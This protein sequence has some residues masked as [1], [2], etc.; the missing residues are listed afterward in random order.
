M[1]AAAVSACS[2]A[3]AL[4]LVGEAELLDLVAAELDQ[5]ERKGLLT[6]LALRIDAPVFPRHEGRDLLFAL[7]DHAQ[8]GALHAAGRQSAPHLLPQQ[9]RQIE[10]DQV[11]E[12]ATRLLRIDQIERQLA[13][14][15]HRCTNRVAR[16]LVEHDAMHG[17]LALELAALLENLGEVPGDRLALAIGVGRQIAATGPSSAP[18]RSPRRG[19]RL[20]SISCVVHGEAVIRDRPRLPSAPDRARG[21]RRPVPRSP[22]PDIS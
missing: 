2:A 6:V 12:R 22:R 18:W 11:V 15:G 20:R 17:L 16:D 14:R 19:A 3:R 1:P 21:H 9:R 7:A 10:S 8:R 4:A 13:R 5:L